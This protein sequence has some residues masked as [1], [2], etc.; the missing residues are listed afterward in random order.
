[1]TLI[2]AVM[3]LGVHTRGIALAL[4]SP[5]TYGQVARYSIKYDGTSDDVSDLVDRHVLRD[6]KNKSRPAV[7]SSRLDALHL[8]RAICRYCILFDWTDEHGVLWRDRLRSSARKE[9]EAAR[10]VRDPEV[11]ARL[12][13]NGRDA[14]DQVMTR[15]LA[16][17]EQLRQ[18]I[19][20]GSGGSS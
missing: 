20:R 7:V 13:L 3:K 5:C 10:Y 1:M 2:H 17:R 11:V 6:G 8:Y 15:F 12:L 14:V 9:F 18:G 16:K 4:P 19:V